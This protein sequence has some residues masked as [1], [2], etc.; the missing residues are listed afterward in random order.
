MG[1]FPIQPLATVVANAR[2]TESHICQKQYKRQDIYFFT[3]TGFISKGVI[4]TGLEF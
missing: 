1:L 2:T 3:A 4:H